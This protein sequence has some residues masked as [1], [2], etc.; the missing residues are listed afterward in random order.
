MSSNTRA[1]MNKIMKNYYY[2]I[3][4]RSETLHLRSKKAEQVN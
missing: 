4:K 2:S 1:E 3:T